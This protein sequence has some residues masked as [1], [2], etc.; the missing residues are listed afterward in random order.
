MS[1]RYIMWFLILKCDITV[2]WH[3]MIMRQEYMRRYLYYIMRGEVSK[4]GRKCK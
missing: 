3:L 1:S 2:V 4:L